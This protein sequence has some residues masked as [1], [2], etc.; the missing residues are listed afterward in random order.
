MNSRLS[1][2]NR[3]N[4]WYP[5]IALL[6][7]VEGDGES[8]RQRV[9][10]EAGHRGADLGLTDAEQVGH[11]EGDGDRDDEGS[12]PEDAE[13]EER[14]VHRPD[15][16]LGCAVR[17]LGGELQR[18]AAHP[19]VRERQVQVD[20]DDQGPDAELGAPERAQEEGGQ[21]QAAQGRDDDDR[22]VRRGVATE[23]CGEP[24]LDAVERLFGRRLARFVTRRN[25][26]CHRS[27]V[28]NARR[29]P[30][31]RPARNAGMCPRPAPGR[32]RFVTDVQRR[33][34]DPS[35]APRPHKQEQ[36]PAS[37]EVTEVAP[38]VHPDAAAH[39]DARARAREHVRPARRPRPRR[40]RP[41]AA[42]A[43][44]AGRR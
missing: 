42:R 5:R 22:G 14:G 3:S 8:R 4:R 9:D 35:A 44:V 17:V 15:E 16:T 21:Q 20:V 39:L 43:A 13:H 31:R 18:R 36:D 38:D 40:R 32:L 19:D 28:T 6:E 41:G 29:R 7:R 33:P 27:M 1:R 23:T 30:S 25:V 34:G 26:L 12:E 11:R 24:V 10:H 2:A 37:D